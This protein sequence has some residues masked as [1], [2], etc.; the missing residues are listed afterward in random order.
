MP[1]LFWADRYKII[2]LSYLKGLILSLFAV[3]VNRQN[4]NIYQIW[5]WCLY[6]INYNINKYI[7]IKTVR[8]NSHLN[9]IVAIV[10]WVC[11]LRV[12]DQ[13][14]LPQAA[15]ELRIALQREHARDRDILV[16][17]LCS[18]DPLIAHCLRLQVQLAR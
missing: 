9:T 12:S 11:F 4:K 3:I 16:F 1:R 13:A 5:S 14:I 7:V 2:L 15:S 10:T 6:H 17:L 18:P 8:H